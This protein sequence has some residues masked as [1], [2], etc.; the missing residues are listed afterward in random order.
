MTEN[1]AAAHIGQQGLKALM[2]MMTVTDTCFSR[3]ED[4]PEHASTISLEAMAEVCASPPIMD[5]LAH[6][7]AFLNPEQERI[8]KDNELGHERSALESLEELIGW[9]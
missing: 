2:D 1:E 3:A 4:L 9:I 6:L 5:N 8:C 7:D